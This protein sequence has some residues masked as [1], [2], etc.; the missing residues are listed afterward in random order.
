MFKLTKE[1]LVVKQEQARKQSEHQDAI[2]AVKKDKA[3]AEA[4]ASQERSRDL[5]LYIQLKIE[6]SRTERAWLEYGLE[7]SRLRQAQ[8]EMW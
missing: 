7:S 4:L 6:E 2:L 1:S 8:R 5:E 3:A